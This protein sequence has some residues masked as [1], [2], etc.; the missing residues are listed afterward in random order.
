MVIV[1]FKYFK[2]HLAY[3]KKAHTHCLG[4]RRDK[5]QSAQL[6]F[7]KLFYLRSFLYISIFNQIDI[8]LLS[9][10]QMNVHIRLCWRTVFYCI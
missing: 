1:V 4:V 6:L 7:H 9:I 10:I 5:A 2:Q 3:L 8:W